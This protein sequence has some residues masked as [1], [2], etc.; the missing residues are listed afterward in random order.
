M[1][2][3]VVRK[4]NLVNPLPTSMVRQGDKSNYGRKAW[5]YRK[6]LPP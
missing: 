5:W 6:V 1:K 4:S 2:M 3:F